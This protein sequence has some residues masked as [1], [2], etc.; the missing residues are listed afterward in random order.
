[1]HESSRCCAKIMC[2]LSRAHIV[3]LV[4]IVEKWNVT[5]SW[6]KRYVQV[7]I[8]LVKLKSSIAVA[9]LGETWANLKV[10]KCINFEAFAIVEIGVGKIINELQVRY[11]TTGGFKI[12]LL[13]KIIAQNFK[14]WHELSQRINISWRATRNNFWEFVA[15][16]QHISIVIGTQWIVSVASTD[17][18]TIEYWFIASLT[19]YRITTMRR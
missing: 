17:Y 10:S 19:K 5:T 15:S 7:L 1:M 13:L 14:Q 9:V 16:F 2:A 18:G 4:V 6:I 3:K 12:L 11:I 8:V